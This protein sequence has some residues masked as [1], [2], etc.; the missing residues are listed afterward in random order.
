MP[1]AERAVD[2]AMERTR[3]VLRTEDRGD[4]VVTMQYHRSGSEL[5]RIETKFEQTK[6]ARRPVE[7]TVSGEGLRM[8]R[9][10]DEREGGSSDDGTAY[11]LKWSYDRMGRVARLHMSLVGESR[12]A[13]FML[14]AVDASG[15]DRADEI[16]RQLELASRSYDE[17]TYSYDASGRLGEIVYRTVLFKP[18]MLDALRL[19]SRE[20]RDDEVMLRMLE[21]K[22]ASDPDAEIRTPPG[23]G[24]VVERIDGGLKQTHTRVHR[25]TEWDSRGRWTKL[26]TFHSDEAG[27]S[28]FRR[29][30]RAIP[31]DRD[32]PRVAGRHWQLF[33]IAPEASEEEHRRLALAFP[34]NGRDDA[35]EASDASDTEASTSVSPSSGPTSG[36][37]VAGLVVVGVAVVVVI[38]LVVLV[39]ILLTQRRTK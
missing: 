13:Q 23:D 3:A 17:W 2:G 18:G 27:E 20:T 26:S 7:M 39:A 22:L 6:D 9:V 34:G 1:L 5:G 15:S 4:V 14:Q 10:G 35:I 38:G 24:I 19:Q 29:T 32:G 25:C 31:Q 30:E 8:F 37:G 36:P 11:L 28:E 16:R 21:Q 12:D 33:G